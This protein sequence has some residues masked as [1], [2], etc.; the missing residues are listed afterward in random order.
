MNELE[1]IVQ[2]MIDAGESE[3]NIAKVVQAY[4]KPV[5]MS[6]PASV[7]ATAGSENNTASSS[8]NTSSESQPEISTWQGIKNSFSNMFE[9]FSDVVEFYRDDGGKD[10]ALDIATNSVYSTIFGQENLENKEQLLGGDVGA[11]NTI[12]ALEL[13][14]QDQM[15]VKT[16]KQ[17]LR[18]AKKGDIGGVINGTINAFTNMIG[19]VAYGTLTGG[20]GYFADFNARNYVEYNKQKAENLG[21]SLDELIKS[22]QADNA[23][24]SALAGASMVAEMLGL[25]VSGAAAIA[26]RGRSAKYSKAISMLPNSLL[27]KVLYSKKARN[28]LLIFG[29][30]AT[31]YATEVTQHAIDEINDELGR[32]AGTDEKPKILETYWNAITS[33][34]GQEAGLQGFIGGGGMV[35]GSYSVKAMTS[36]RGEVDGDKLDNNISELFS[37]QKQLNTTKDQTIREG[38]EAKI[39]N[40]E[41][42]ISD[43]VQKGNDIYNS[44]DD[45]QLSQLESFNDLSDATAFKITELNKKLRNNQISEQQYNIAKEGFMAEYNSAKQSIADMKLTEN[46]QFLKSTVKDKKFA[47]NIET[48]ILNTT[49]ETETAMDNLSQVDKKSKQEF[50]DNKGNIAGFTVNGKIF[51]N[52]EVARKT[53]QINVAKHEFLHKVMNAKVGGV[54]EQGKIV[55][56]LRRAMSSKQRSIVDAEMKARG[57]TSLKEYNT[58]YVQVFSDLINQEKVSFEQSAMGKAGDAILRFFK[59]QGFDQI[60]FK[61]GRG[62][63]N[64]LKDYSKNTKELSAEAEAAIGDVDLAQEG[65]LQKSQIS[66]S[67]I[68]ARKGELDGTRDKAMIVAYDNNFQDETLRRLR[69]VNLDEETKKDIA[70]SFILDDKRGLTKLLMEYDP[71]VNDSVMGYLNSFVP[72]TKRSLFDVRLQEFYEKDPR[73]KNIIQST[74][75]ENVQIKVAK[76]EAKQEG[77]DVSIDKKPVKAGPRKLTSFIDVEANTKEKF[78]NKDIQTKVNEL[79]TKA[80]TKGLLEGK[81]ITELTDNMYSIIEKDVVDFLKTK[82][83]KI[84]KIKGEIVIDPKYQE[85]INAGF[86]TIMKAYPTARLKKLPFVKKTKIGFKD[87]VTKK[88]DKPSLK[89]DSYYRKADFELSVIPAEGKKYYLQGGYTTLIARQKQLLAD[90]AG[91]FALVEMKKLRN[92]QEALSKIVEGSDVAVVQ[93]QGVLDDIV[94]YMDPKSQEKYSGDNIQ[95]SK[96]AHSIA[97]EN[98]SFMNKLKNII[99][100]NKGAFVNQ[101]RDFMLTGKGNYIEKTIK[102]LLNSDLEGLGITKQQ[103]DKIAKEIG[104]NWVIKNVEN[105]TK[106]Y[107][108]KK[109]QDFLVNNI[110][111]NLNKPVGFEAINASLGVSNMQDLN[112]LDSINQARLAIQYIFNSLDLNDFVRFVYPSAMGPA[113]LAGFKQKAGAVI[114]GIKVLASQ[115]VNN[116]KSARDVMF[117]SAQDIKQALGFEVERGSQRN[118][119]TFKHKPWFNN[120]NSDYNQSDNDGKIKFV[121][122]LYDESQQEKKAATK[123]LEIIKVGYDNG[124]LSLEQVQWLMRNFFAHQFSVGKVM[125][126]VRF[127]PSDMNGNILTRQQMEE[128]GLANKGDEYVLEHMLPARHIR[129]AAYLYILTGDKTLFNQEIDNYNVAIIPKKQDNILKD[130][131]VQSKMGINHVAGMDPMNTRYEGMGMYFVDVVKS[132]PGKPVVVGNSVQFS[133]SEFKD[134]QISNNAYA[135]MKDEAA[136]VKGISVFD[137]DDTLARTNSKIVVKLPGKKAFKINATEFASRSADL[138]AAGATFDF[139][140]FNEVID[141]KK[142]PL[143]ELAMK[144]QEKFGNKNIFILTARPQE[145]AYAI[146]AFLKGIGLEIPIDNITG[147]EDGRPQAKA[148]WIRSKAAEGYNDFYFADDAYKNVDAVQKELKGLGLNPNVEQAKVQ[149]SKS[150]QYS[151][152]RNQDS[153]VIFNRILQETKGVDSR[154][155]V[156]RAAAKAKGQGISNT[157]FVPPGAEDFVGLIYQFLGKGKLGE[158]H[159]EFFNERLFKPFARATAEMNKVRQSYVNSY[160]ALKDKYPNLKSKMLEKASNGFFKEDAVRVYIWNRLGYN[161]PGLSKNDIDSMVR[162]VNKDYELRS[163]ADSLISLTRDKSYVRP[164][165]SWLDGNVAS[166][167]NDLTSRTRRKEFLKQWIHQKNQIFSEKNLNKIESIYGSDFRSALEDI[168]WRMENGTNRKFG[169]NKLVNQFS[170]WVNNSVGAIMFFNMRSAVLQ[171]ISMFNFINWSDNN[172]LKAMGAIANTP[173]YASDFATI[174]NSDMLKQRRSGLTQDINEAEIAAAIK[175]KGNTPQALLKYLL[176]KGFLP[177]QMADSFAIASGG[178]TFYRNRINTYVKQGMDISKAEKQAFQDFAEISEKTQQSARPDLISQQQAGPLGRLILAFQNTPMQYTRLMK[179]AY[180][181]LI[182]GRG[183]AKTNIS[184]LAYYGFVQNLIFTTLQSALFAVAFEDDEDEKEEMLDK[185]VP[186]ILNNM[187]DTILRGTGIYGAG[188]STVKNIILKFIEQDKKGFRADHTYTVI[189]FANLSPPIGSKLRRLY[190]GIQT[191]KFNKD[192]IPVYGP[193]IG[194]PIYQVVGNTVSAFTNVPLDRAVNKINNVRAALNRENTTWQRIANFLGWNTWDVGSESDPDMPAIKK[195]AKKRAKFNKSRDKARK[196]YYKRRK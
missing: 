10:S 125:A 9:Q 123:I 154:T 108:V 189:E 111:S 82:A 29:A 190:S 55:K 164:T 130:I 80:I 139:K 67:D 58:E 180:L 25:I 159:L 92:N 94:T 35:G 131:G 53:G 105:K 6:D 177:T 178:A 21:V 193:G 33:L 144:R 16:T 89:K 102:Q 7:E 81:T 173:Q 191:Y 20:L 104:S 17:I 118:P 113:R 107:D 63:Y 78:Y 116:D 146:H 100:S 97:R 149:F 112:S 32:V 51:V 88:A 76:K 52:K 141:G 37:A 69:N 137:F 134:Q 194:N 45:G 15:E 122:N 28:G 138:E 148:E 59:G 38:L 18:S 22:G 136:P 4:G 91:D 147:L 103:A 99:G 187:A 85:L 73:Y 86:G 57:Y 145:A 14:E 72:G 24:P 62:V 64:F 77:V 60:S 183:D 48:N 170:N 184:K 93:A 98:T 8:E 176:T 143:F 182:N 83:G 186:R 95:F 40:L 192:V 160:K 42:A 152:N 1:V 70:Q 166:D 43:Q 128:Q 155:N 2:R 74:S 13:Y 101:Y 106:K 157:W 171:T 26:T 61:D 3:E 140:E 195:E 27:K 96:T 110:V 172:P 19:S 75:E 36:V 71:N 79:I 124:N 156:S 49:A 185:K 151:I 135:N 84:S 120:D 167:I 165:E 47:K 44:L 127:I 188:A 169:Q 30:G 50:R 158:Q 12:E 34:E 129:D 162:D 150:Q 65:G 126:G 5:K 161:I 56:Q 39:A 153:D 109:T 117:A 114:K 179:K 181:D 31:E 142:G 11:E 66:Y 54:S 196:D 87:K 132:K 41:M 168:L 119:D 90:M 163:Y 115:V 175:G 46:I 133:K 23:I 174:F 121:K 68:E